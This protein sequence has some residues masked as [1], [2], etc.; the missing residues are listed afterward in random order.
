MDGE[1]Q[2]PAFPVCFA[3]PE[4]LLRTETTVVCQLDFCC[5]WLLCCVFFHHLFLCYLSV[6]LGCREVALVQAR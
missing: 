6:P 3:A 4:C 1:E 2:V 5:W